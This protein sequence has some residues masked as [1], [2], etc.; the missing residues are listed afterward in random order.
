MTEHCVRSQYV[1]VNLNQCLNQP[2]SVSI[3]QPHVSSFSHISIYIYI[4]TD[5]CMS[6]SA[7]AS[8]DQTWRNSTSGTSQNACHLI[9]TF[10]ICCKTYWFYGITKK[11]SNW[12]EQF[13]QPLHNSTTA[14]HSYH[15]QGPAAKGDTTT[16]TTTFIL[17][18]NNSCFLMRVCAKS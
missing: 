1:S 6:V 8:H 17:R 18:L 9:H 10:G 3:C 14:T 16:A 7:S 13:L 15:K 2:Q 4:H 5:G 11:G 12:I